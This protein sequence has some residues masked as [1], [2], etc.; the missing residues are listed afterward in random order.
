L[1]TIANHEVIE[2]KTSHFPKGLVPLETL[3]ESND[4]RVEP[5]IQ[6]SE[7]KIISC[8]LGT[9]LQ[10]KFFNLSNSLPTE[11]KQR[12]VDLLKDFSYVSF[13]GPMRI[14]K[15]MTPVLFNTGFL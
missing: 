10:P 12:Y 11:M 5:T 3:F 4:V 7:D 1:N 8:N 13:L 9:K 2:L 15:L 6:S 14:L